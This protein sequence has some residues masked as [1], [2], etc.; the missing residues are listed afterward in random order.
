MWQRLV[1]LIS[2]VVLVVPVS[3]YGQSKVGTA[4]AQFLEIAPSARVAG[5]GEAFVAITDDASG[6][7]YN[8]AGPAWLSQREL[9]TNGTQY[10]AGINVYY[11]GLLFPTTRFGVVGGSFTAL[12][13]DDM[14][15]TTPFHPEGT[16]ENFTCSEYAAQLTYSRMLTERFSTGLSVRYVQSYL[17]EE[18]AWGVS[19][20]VGTLY[21][22]GFKT[23]KMGMCISN[24]GPDMIYITESFPLPMNFKV[25]VSFEPI[26]G[27]MHHLVVDI[28]GHHP[29]HNVE[30]GIVGGEYSFRNMFFL[31]GGY[32][33][34]YDAET[35]STGIGFALPLGGTIIKVDAAYTDFGFLTDIKRISLGM[36]F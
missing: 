19:G 7:F 31:R 16:G 29:N 32:K 1:G 20:D 9:L 21:D 15:I 34:N 6:L 28:E 36:E 24:F 2:V 23:I 27:G 13:M 30:Q 3:L 8:P 35:W 33:I 11:T 10:P 26:H 25:G 17:E 18:S 22:T 4:G 5:M 12:I 14:P